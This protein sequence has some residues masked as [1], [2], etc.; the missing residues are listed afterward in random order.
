MR[1]QSHISEWKFNVERTVYNI[2]K[3]ERFS[4]YE[5]TEYIWSSR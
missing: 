3:A 4:Y 2:S 1:R 5:I